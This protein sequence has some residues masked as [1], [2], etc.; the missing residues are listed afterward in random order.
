M[1]ATLTAEAAKARFLAEQRV[2]F[3]PARL[4]VE[5]AVCRSD[6]GGNSWTT[7]AKAKQVARMLENRAIYCWRSAW[8]Q[9]GQQFIWPGAPAAMYGTT[10][11]TVNVAAATAR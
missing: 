11:G 9:A 10:Y 2:A 4:A 6:Y 3:A 1:P 5:C 8:G 7:M